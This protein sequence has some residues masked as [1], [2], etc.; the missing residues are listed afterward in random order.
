[1][2]PSWHLKPGDRTTRAELVARYGGSVQSGGIV[3]SRTSSF[4][5]VF[6]DADEGAHF[7]YSQHDGVTDDG[8]G[9]DYTGAGQEGDQVFLRGNKNLLNHTSDR[10]CLQLFISAG[11]V[12]GSS[13]KWQEYVGEYAVRDDD[14]GPFRYAR[15]PDKNGNDRTVVVFHLQRLGSGVAPL[16]IPR[17]DPTLAAGSPFLVPIEVDRTYISARKA[18][19]AGTAS[20]R[21][22]ELTRKFT[23]WLE[24]QSRSARRWA[25]PIAGGTSLMTDYFT[26]D[27]KT[28]F[29]AKASSSR[30]DVRMAVGQLHDYRNNLGLNGLRCALLLPKAPAPDL[31]TLLESIGFGCVVDVNDEFVWLVEARQ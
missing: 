30:N 11:T 4:V 15:A 7:G 19:K 6:S 24:S 31:V 21:E 20:R 22:A 26:E 25:I 14:R 8:Y 29:E 27:D 10:K 18:S 17:T 28:L 16:D 1:M 3:P 2:T 23:S 5:M 12:P 13:T 9:F